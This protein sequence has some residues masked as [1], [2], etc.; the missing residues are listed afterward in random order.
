MRV[1]LRLCPR[2]IHTPSTRAR[3]PA[4]VGIRVRSLY[5]CVRVPVLARVIGIYL[6]YTRERGRRAERGYDSSSQYRDDR[7]AATDRSKHRCVSIPVRYVGKEERHVRSPCISNDPPG[8]SERL[9]EKKKVPLPPPQVIPKKV[10]RVV[11]SGRSGPQFLKF[12]SDL[13]SPGSV[14]YL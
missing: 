13:S 5:A 14:L 2:N 9:F 6:V 1:R 7:R 3:A 11:K 8:A 12:L 10:L 4:Y